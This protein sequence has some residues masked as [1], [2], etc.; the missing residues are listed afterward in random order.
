MKQTASKGSHLSTRT[1]SVPSTS[2]ASKQD[3]STNHQ[4]RKASAYLHLPVTNPPRAL[5]LWEVPPQQV[6]KPGA[7]PT[8]VCGRYSTSLQNPPMQPK[9]GR[10]GP[11]KCPRC[12]TGYSRVDTVRAHFPSCIALNGNPDCLSWTDH[13]TYA[14]G[15]AERNASRAEEGVVRKA[16]KLS[17]Q[18]NPSLSHLKLVC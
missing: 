7:T 18:Q 11:Y 10:Q 13:D 6:C 17:V 4:H 3:A 14:A 8:A 15:V 1:P 16:R 9:R 5:A 2:S 12:C